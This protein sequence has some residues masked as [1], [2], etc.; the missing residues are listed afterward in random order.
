[1]VTLAPP[2]PVCASSDRTD[3]APRPRAHALI[4]RCAIASALLAAHLSAI[5]PSP[6]Q[7]QHG[8]TP[9]TYTLTA[10]TAQ[11]GLLPGDVLA[12]AEDR[13]GYLWLGTSTGLVRFDGAVF[14]PRDT[15]PDSTSTGNASVAVIVGARDGTVWAG[16]GGTGGISRFSGDEVTRFAPADGLFAGAVGA[17]VEDRNGTIWAGGRG[18]LA[19]FRD[20]RWERLDERHGWHNAAVHSI[21]EDRAGRLWLGTSGG[22]FTR[23]GSRFEL[24]EPRATFVQDFAEDRSGTMWIT[25]TRE[26]IKRLGGGEA[27]VHGPTV[28]VPQSAWR[29]T[30]D[31]NGQLWIA[32]LGGG[33]LRLVDDSTAPPRIERFAYESRIAGSPRAVFLDRNGNLWI[34]MRGGGLLRVAESSFQTGIPLEGLTND[35]VRA[36]HAGADGSVWVATGHSLNRFSGDRRDVLELAQTRALET[37]GAGNVW[38][39]TARGVGRLDRGGFA[40]TELPPDI[41]WEGIVAMAIDADGDHWLCSSEQGLMLWDDRTLRRFDHAPELHDRSCSSVYADRRGR[42]WIGF[43]SGGL[44]M[45]SAGRVEQFD[46]EDGLAIGAVIAILEERSGAIWVMTRSGLSRFQDGRFTTVTQRNGPFADLVAAFVQ[47]DEGYLWVGVN[48]GAALVRF[49]PGEM[50]RVLADPLRTIEYALYDSSD[51]LQGGDRLAAEPRPRRPWQ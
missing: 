29:M 14:T 26:T 3:R 30:A 34:G 46:E 18:G 39:A 43:T 35:G 23:T 25:D 40:A 9:P 33:L 12:I 20:G 4:R 24:R 13:D 6:A 51:G 47:D 10:W 28:R 32:A 17:L 27:P 48:A 50:D 31:R 15:R 8:G 19:A 22:V 7:S 38:A 45:H 16:H 41:Q 44:V 21:Y 42:Q 5:P 2:P 36:I 49:R 11:A 37:D 1:M